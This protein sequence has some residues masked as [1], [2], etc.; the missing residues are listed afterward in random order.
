MEGLTPLHP[1]V[2][3]IDVHR[4][5]H[6]VTVLITEA[7]GSI[8]KQQREFGGFKRDLRALADWLRMLQV[9][10]VVMESTGIYWKSAY[11]HLERADIPTWVVNAHVIKHVP[12]RKTDLGDSEWLAIL[13]RFGLVRGSFIPPQDLRELRLVSRYR[14][15]LT[16]QR[17]SEINRLHKVLD[18]GGV[19]LGGVVADLQ[20]VSARAMV[21]G[22]VAGKSLPDLLAMTRGSLKHK[23]ALL[24]EALD[25][26]L[27]PRHLLVLRTVQEHIAY[28]DQEIA[29]LDAYL[30]TAMQPYQWAWELLQTIPGIDAITSALLLIEIGDDMTCFGSAERLA[31]WAALCPGNH[32][33]AGKRTSGKTRKGNGMV[34]ALLCECANAARRTKSS[35]ASYYRSLHVRKSHKKCIVAVAHKLLRIVYVLLARRVPYRDPGV[36]Y[37]AMSAQKNAP[38]WIKALQKIGKLPRVTATFA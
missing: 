29:T 6:V 18:D 35:L 36:D 38:R 33:S 1:C 13:A 2:A 8:T 16:Q 11:S 23:R 34:R 9:R 12:G 31:S 28:L 14:R 24:T 17:A 32:A 10:L 3:G 22:L 20:G 26:D 30:F 21:A 5:L 4:L 15:K 25:G 19:K 7:D 37:A 27:S